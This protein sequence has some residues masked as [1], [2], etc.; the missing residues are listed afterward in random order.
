MMVSGRV[1]RTAS[2][3]GAL[4]VLSGLLWLIP[5]LLAEAAQPWALVREIFS[6]QESLLEESEKLDR[7]NEVVRWRIEVKD[8]VIQELLQGRLSLLE[9][10]ACFQVV[11][12]QSPRLPSLSDNRSGSPEE[13]AC[14]QVIIWVRTQLT[15]HSDPRV[16]RDLH[17]SGNG[18]EPAPEAAR[19]LDLAVAAG[20]AG[21]VAGAGAGSLAAPAGSRASSPFF[22]LAPK[23]REVG[24]GG[25]TA[26]QSRS[27]DTR[28]NPSPQ[29]LSSF[30]FP[31]TGVLTL[32][33]TANGA[34]VRIVL[35]C[36][37]AERSLGE[38][39]AWSAAA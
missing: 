21:Q 9:A 18:T 2:L 20:S 10:A 12:N 6:Q 33:E 15:M 5:A 30:Q 28:S 3:L 4:V 23:G 26:D 31:L 36:Q 1:L 35:P 34:M 16:S 7:Q 27:L 14:R 19:W 37:A 22:S 17:Q 8:Q 25:G 24:V 39:F 11:N 13:Q 29:P 38:L 32:P